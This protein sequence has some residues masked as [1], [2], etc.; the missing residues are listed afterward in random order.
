MQKI[1]ENSFSNFGSIY[2]HPVASERYDLICKKLE[3]KQF[4]VNELFCFSCKVYI[5]PTY[6][7]GSIIVGKTPNVDQLYDFPLHH[8]LILKPNL[9]FN[10]ISKSNIFNFSILTP[11]DIMPTKTYLNTPYK[12]EKISMSFNI[13]KVIEYFYKSQE[14]PCTFHKPPHNC[15]EL[16]YVCSGYITI[17]QSYGKSYILN[18]HDLILLS[19]NDKFGRNFSLNSSCSYLSIII[20]INILSDVCILDK[21]FSCPVEL[22][23]ILWKI[24]QET[25]TNTKHSQMLLLCHLQECIAEMINLER[26]FNLNKNEIKTK[27]FQNNQLKKILSY[28]NSNITE[29]ITIEDIC[30]EFFM[31]RSSLQ[32]LFKNNLGCSPKNYL[33]NIKLQKSK[34]LLRKNQHTISQIA[35]LLG[36]SSIHYFSRLFKKYFNI[37]PS[38]YSR[39][40]QINKNND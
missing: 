14:T 12:S 35:Y 34:E 20:D 13:S 38:D 2:F 15:Y 21:I 5:E 19:P 23:A 10:I 11:D 28:M 24:I 16:L 36:F 7:V 29:P 22:Q 37:S 17:S 31:S 39:G 3:T 26:E 9:Y 6:G 4:D 27:N 18:T 25:S 1:T 33:I 32:S 30:H 40:I 8:C